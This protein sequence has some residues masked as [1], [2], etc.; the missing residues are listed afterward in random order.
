[1]SKEGVYMSHKLHREVREGKV[2]RVSLVSMR[3]FVS[4][5]PASQLPWSSYPYC[6]NKG[7]TPK[8][9]GKPSVPRYLGSLFSVWRQINEYILPFIYYYV[10]NSTSITSPGG[11]ERFTQ[12]N[13]PR[14]ER[15]G[16]LILTVVYNWYTLI[17]VKGDA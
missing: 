13:K 2:L 12:N 15:R 4:P 1:M 6:I 5:A 9:R 11:A 8:I 10:Y 14:I 7:R 17:T 16:N 3:R